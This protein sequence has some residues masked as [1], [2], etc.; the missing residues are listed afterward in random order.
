MTRGSLWY[1]FDW[2]PARFYVLETA[3]SDLAANQY[4]SDFEAHWN[5]PVPGCPACGTER[6]WL[7][8]DLAAHAGTALKFA[9]FHYPLHSD[10]LHGSD[11]FLTGPDSLEELLAGNGVDIVFNGHDHHYQRNNPTVA[12]SNMVSYVTGGG[13]Q[14]LYPVSGCSATTAYAV[15]ASGTSCNGPARTPASK[16]HHFLLVTV[17]G[18]DVTVTPTDSTGETFD[19]QTFD[20]SGP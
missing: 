9:F 10:A 11:A 3:W 17:N 20:F 13:G 12:D 7:A 14:F 4:E 19:V 18:T 6:D 16:V 2:G 1:A 8:A 5:G 15:G